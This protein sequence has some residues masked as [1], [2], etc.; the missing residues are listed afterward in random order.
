MCAAAGDM[1][2][3]RP[4]SRSRGAVRRREVS[5]CDRL[6][7]QLEQRRLLSAGAIISGSVEDVTGGGAPAPV[8][9]WGVYIDAN[10]NGKIDPG[11]QWT[12]TDAAGHFAFPPLAAG[13]YTIRADPPH[14]Q[15][16]V[17]SPS[18][19]FFAVT[20][21]GLDPSPPVTFT[22]REQPPPSRYQVSQIVDFQL[23]GGGGPD[24]SIR[25]VPAL[26]QSAG[27]EGFV[28]TVVQPDWAWGVRRIELHNPF[29]LLPGDAIFP[30][31]QFLQA[32]AA[33]LH[34]LT[35]DFVSAW[36]PVT[37]SG[38]EVI[39]Y[40]GSPDI[41]PTFQALAAAGNTDAWNARFNAS[42][43][44]LLQAGMSIA[45]DSGQAMTEGDLF[46]QALQSLTAQGV[47]VYLEN[48]PPE[49]A[50][51]QWS[52]PVIETADSWVN[53]DPYVNPATFWAAKNSQLPAG[54]VVRIV[55]AF[56]ANVDP[57]SSPQ[58]INYLQGILRDGD[59]AAI[60]IGTVRQMGISLADL[61]TSVETA[62]AG[63]PAGAAIGGALRD[64][65]GSALSGWTIYL[66]MNHDG[67]LDAGDIST[68][69][70]AYLGWYAFKDLPAG[71]YTVRYVARPD[72]APAPGSSDHLDVTVPA[73]Q[74]IASQDMRLMPV[75]SGNSGLSSGALAAAVAAD[76]QQ[77]AA[78]ATRLA[79][80]G[81]DRRAVLAADAKAIADAKTKGRASSATAEPRL[82]GTALR[83]RLARLRAALR[84]D[85]L[86]WKQ[87]LAADHALLG[88]DRQ[89][90]AL[91]RRMLRR[92]RH[93][94]VK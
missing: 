1:P 43:A 53:S 45:F 91:D 89:K 86:R 12:S 51:F 29:G 28:S 63:S 93:A 61:L 34:W 94:P 36:K 25:M 9:H 44:P 85:M 88:A 78:D 18:S 39:G 38:M 64:S 75:P 40:I 57:T 15:W 7:E 23:I 35:D 33:G 66:D 5:R 79:S 47:K 68:T 21:D 52:F 59:S 24:P 8:A 80:D 11:E 84:A 30:T 32:Q 65:A 46:Y 87:V 71:T 3:E 26:L 77:L 70:S 16:A 50:P 42:I 58:V 72:H 22:Y 83:D 19:G 62:P 69:T 17:S 41:D 56:P 54:S 49:D 67:I 20:S 14:P 60:A 90:L 48:R 4:P 37:Q 31:D 74:T 76:Q 13:T 27:W 2:A 10:N 6:L 81:Q 55:N 82:Q 92:S 73:G